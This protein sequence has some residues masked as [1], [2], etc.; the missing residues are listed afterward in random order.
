MALKNDEKIIFFCKK[1]KNTQ[2]RNHASINSGKLNFRINLK[3]HF[4]TLN[5]SLV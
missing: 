3:E 5:K 4:F 1:R 2:I